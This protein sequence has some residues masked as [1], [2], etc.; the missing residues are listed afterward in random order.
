[1]KRGIEGLKNVRP[2]GGSNQD[3]LNAFMRPCLRG[4]LLAIHSY[5]CLARQLLDKLKERH[6]VDG[7]G[8]MGVKSRLN[9]ACAV[10]I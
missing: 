1:M 5:L 10:V 3:G 7:L 6:R 8:N 9:R 2:E 4:A